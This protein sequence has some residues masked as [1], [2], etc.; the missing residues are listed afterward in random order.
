LYLI[1]ILKPT[2]R[3]VRNDDECDTAA[4]VY[5]CGRDEAPEIT[6]IIYNRTYGNYTEVEYILQSRILI[7]KYQLKLLQFSEK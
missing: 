3:A 4:N 2:F 7:I 1:N 6:A 5:Q